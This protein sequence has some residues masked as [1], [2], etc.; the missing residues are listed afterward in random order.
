MGIDGI[1]SG[2]RIPPGGPGGVGGKSPTAGPKGTSSTSSTFQVGE[3]REKTSAASTGTTSATSAVDPAART[4]LERL[5]AGEIDVN[6]YVEAK[7][8]VATRGLS[9]LS[10]ADLDQIRG[11]LKHQMAHDPA[12][13]DLVKQAAGALP[14]PEGE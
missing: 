2:G 6:G 12:V 10:R 4:P 11:I 5:R 8:D 9:G 7:V 3:V 14:K 13:M 1:G